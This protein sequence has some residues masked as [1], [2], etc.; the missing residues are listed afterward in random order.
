MNKQGK[1]K[2]RSETIKIDTEESLDVPSQSPLVSDVMASFEEFKYDIVSR[3]EAQ[4]NILEEIADRL[5]QVEDS[6][7]LV[8]LTLTSNGLDRN[9]I[10]ASFNVPVESEP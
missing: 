8:T 4:Y 1:R 6:I 7:G 5:D 9:G 10:A 3:F 2:R